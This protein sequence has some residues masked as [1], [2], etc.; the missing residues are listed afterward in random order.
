MERSVSVTYLQKEPLSNPPRC[1]L[2][3]PDGL[4]GDPVVYPIR[5]T[6]EDTERIRERLEEVLGL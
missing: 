1:I 2:E 4:A 6:D 3:W 5:D